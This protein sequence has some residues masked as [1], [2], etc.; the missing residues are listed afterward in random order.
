MTTPQ[1]FL[2]ANHLHHDKFL[3]AH[4]LSF[5]YGPVTALKDVSFE[6]CKGERSAVVG[7][8]GAGKST[9]FKLIV[10]LLAPT[11]GTLSFEGYDSGQ[12]PPIA[13][14]PQRNDVD[15]RFPLSVRD[16]VMM[17]RAAHIGL[18][19][20]PSAEDRRVVEEAL[21]HVRL[22]GLADRQIN[23]LSGGQQQR[24]FIAQA[25]AQQ[26]KMVLMD[27]PLNGLDLKAQQDVYAV[28]DFLREQEV[29]VFISTHDLDQAAAHFDRV[30]LLNH[31][32]QDFDVPTR[33]FTPDQLS[34][35][36]GAGLR[37]VQTDEGYLLVGD[38]VAHSH[39]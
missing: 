6:L 27:E 39:G 18:F 9:L 16:V 12:R 20:R 3:S 29:T 19:G 34:A 13:Y 4:E 21:V 25:L 26:A 15:W 1:C 37:L 11:R 5:S 28:L 23:A 10:G 32:M 31:T 36:Y 17:G 30:M 22:D 33:V 24:M 35:V 38:E 7:P 2:A 8:N 14:V